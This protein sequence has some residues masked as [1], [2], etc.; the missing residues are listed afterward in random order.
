MRMDYVFTFN[1]LHISVY[2]ISYDIMMYIYICNS[3]ESLFLSPERGNQITDTWKEL[4]S[5]SYSNRSELI[6]ERLHIYKI[7]RPKKDRPKH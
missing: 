1:H 5:C 6:E 3:R 2:R 4:L 7:L